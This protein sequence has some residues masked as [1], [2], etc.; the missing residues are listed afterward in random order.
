MF[1][2]VPS[3]RRYT[4]PCAPGEGISLMI[5][6]GRF[7]RAP[8]D[9]DDGRRSNMQVRSGKTTRRGGRQRNWVF[10]GAGGAR[11]TAGGKGVGFRFFFFKKKRDE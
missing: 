5:P 8:S 10:S 2:R 6:A 7:D 11:N 1:L 4:D 9:D 3:G